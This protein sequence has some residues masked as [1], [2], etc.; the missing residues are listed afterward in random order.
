MD[1]EDFKF[2]IRE[3][4]YAQFDISRA[5]GENRAVAAVEQLMNNRQLVDDI[6]TADSIILNITGS[7]DLHFDE[8]KLIVE[9]IQSKIKPE[10]HMIF[11]TVIDEEAQ[12]NLLLTIVAAG[13]VHRKQKI[14]HTLWTTTGNK[15]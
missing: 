4:G 6:R 11:G 13:T 10:A 9:T 5:A 15:P 8:V 3:K 7:K 14:V 2:L 1:L 12:D